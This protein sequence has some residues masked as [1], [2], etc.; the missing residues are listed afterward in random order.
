MLP[1]EP[2][3]APRRSPHPAQVACLIVGWAVIVF[4]IHGMISEPASNPPNLFRLL[5]GLNV[6]NDALIIPVVLAISLLVRRAL[7]RWAHPA[8]AGRA[9]RVGGRRAL[10][11]PAPRR[12]EPYRPGGTVPTP[13]RLRRQPRLGAGDHLAGLRPRGHHSTAMATSSRELLS[14][15]SDRRRARETR[16]PR[17]RPRGGTRVGLSSSPRRWRPLPSTFSWHCGASA[18]PS[19]SSG[20]KGVRSRSSTGWSTARGS[21]SPPRST[22]SRTRILPSSFGSRLHS[23][24]FSAWA[25][26][27]PGWSPSWRPSA[28]WRSSSTS[29]DARRATPWLPSSLQGCLPPPFRRAARTST[30]RG[31]TRSSWRCCLPRSPSRRRGENLAAVAQRSASSFSSPSSRNRRPSSPQCRCCCS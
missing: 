28:C 31:W 21:T 7:P 11:L 16:W 10:R 13:P 26:W 30:W 12:M 15:P 23:P 1:P 3:V 27:P 8:R 25:S 18:I 17:R 24:R 20:S 4:A 19:S 6:F 5:I 29:S 9:V 2:I 22:M 14:T